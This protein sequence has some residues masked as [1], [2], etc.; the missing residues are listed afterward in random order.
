MA[1]QHQYIALITSLPYLGKL[2]SRK[3]VPISEYRLRQRLS[4]LE[5]RHTDLLKQILKVITWAGVAPLEDEQTVIRLAREVVAGLEA[6]PDLQH[7]VSSRME[8]R[9]LIAA[10]RRRRDGQDTPGNVEAWGYGRWCNFIHANWSDPS[11][12]LGHFM[13][14]VGEAHRLLQSGDHIGMERLALTQVF[15]QLDHYNKTHEFDF[16]A[17]CI[18]VLRWTVVQRWARYNLQDARDRL[19]HMVQ[20]A[21]DG[22]PKKAAPTPEGSILSA[23]F[24]SFL[25]GVPS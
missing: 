5:D 19:Q 9:T 21:L 3:D 18:Y 12:G 25:E 16:E 6:H 1:G 13:P 11:F 20:L 4:M 17:V 23:D 2:F 15:E 24:P 22:D 8:T 10:L 14:W 7:L